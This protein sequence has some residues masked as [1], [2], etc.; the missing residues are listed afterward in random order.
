MPKHIKATRLR[1]IH[2]PANNIAWCDALLTKRFLE[3]GAIDVEGYKAMEASFGQQHRGQKQHSRF[4]RPMCSAVQRQADSDECGKVENGDKSGRAKRS[5]AK[6]TAASRQSTFS[7]D[8]SNSENAEIRPLRV[9]KSSLSGTVS[10]AQDQTAESLQQTSDAASTSMNVTK[11]DGRREQR[12]KQPAGLEALSRK[13]DAG[14]HEPPAK[15]SAKEVGFK[16]DARQQMSRNNTMDSSI[17]SIRTKQASTSNV[18]LFMPYLHFE[19]DERR[20]EMQEAIEHL[21]YPD[22]QMSLHEDEVLIRAHLTASGSFLH[23]RRTLDQFFYHNI[24]TQMRDADQVVYRYQKRHQDELSGDPK[25]FMVDQLWMWII[26]KDLVVTSFPRRWKQPRNDP[27]NVLDGIIEDINSK[28]RKPI[29]NVYELAMTITGRCYGDFDRKGGEELQFFD[30]FEASLGAAMDHEAF[31][32]QQFLEASYHASSWL[33]EHKRAERFSQPAF[34]DKL[35]DVGAETALLAE[36][37]DIRDELNIIRMV[38]GYQEGL[39]GDFRKVV[40]NVYEQERSHVQL[41]LVEKIFDDQ[42]KTISNP[43][44]DISRMSEQAERIYISITDLLDLKQKHANAFEARFARDQAAGTIRQG[45]TIL[46]FTI[47]TVI[48]LPLTFI[49]GVFAINLE[50]WPAP[51][52]LPYVSEYIFG[53]GLG[54]S[55]PCIVIAMTV[56]EIFSFFSKIKVMVL[57]LWPRRDDDDRGAQ[58]QLLIM[59][60]S[61]S[62][63][64]SMRQSMEIRRGLQEVE[65]K[66]LDRNMSPWQDVRNRNRFG[67]RNWDVERGRR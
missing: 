3:E 23:L 66:A 34:V 31:L 12:M 9:P 63:A 29:E 8:I 13:G 57:Q 43:L 20:R 56:D 65:T 52:T 62:M 4:M 55:I 67:R 16:K 58:Q 30:M 54:I 18:Y 60:E 21:R 25:I 46:V 19:S 32:F 44:K 64:K 51:L 24:D 28:T 15:K 7:S 40:R 10:M 53:I 35:L 1:W 47:V 39:V 11:T 22:H 38:L 36:I 41:R 50:D 17:S 49:A 42:E 2:L 14:K 61:L 33:L 59:D 5:P 48:F 37:K 45:R 6:Q 27:L 26:G